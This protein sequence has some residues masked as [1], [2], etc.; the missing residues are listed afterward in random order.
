MRL[1]SHHLLFT[2]LCTCASLAMDRPTARHYPND[3]EPAE[4]PIIQRTDPYGRAIQSSLLKTRS[5]YGRMIFLPSFGPEVSISVYSLDELFYIHVC[6]AESPIYSAVSNGT[7][8]PRIKMWTK[9][10]DRPLA[11]AVRQVWRK[12]IHQAR[13]HDTDYRGA[14][15]VMLEFSVIL[16]DGHEYSAETWTPESPTIL[17]LE[18][19]AWALSYLAADTKTTKRKN[20]AEI[21]S[22]C[23]DFLKLSSVPARGK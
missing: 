3:L 21:I 16:E 20:T 18:E 10:I 1:L 6:E 8:L 9:P 4:L 15:G 13:V 19:I 22:M 5:D 11:E 7:N 12:A 14:D 2:I 17:L 23:E